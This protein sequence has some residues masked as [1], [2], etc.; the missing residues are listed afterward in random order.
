MSGTGKLWAG[1]DDAPPSSHPPEMLLNS[2]SN[3]NMWRENPNQQV[4]VIF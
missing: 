2:D 3:I 4:A 1:I